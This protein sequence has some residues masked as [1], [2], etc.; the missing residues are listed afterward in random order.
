MTLEAKTIEARNDR[1]LS[2][3]EVAR[4]WRVSPRKVRLLIRR[5]WLQAIDLGGVG[6]QQ[7]RVTPEGI[8]ECERRMTV[9]RPTPRRQVPRDI[10]PEILEM[11]NRL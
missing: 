10:D 6:R 1:C 5:G 9:R 11:L 7:L 3:R 8:A 2:V 4:R